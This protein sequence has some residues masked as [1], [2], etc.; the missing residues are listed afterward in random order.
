MEKIIHNSTIN[1]ALKILSIF[2]MLFSG[3]IGI[4]NF[5]ADMKLLLILAVFMLF[6]V[7][8]PGIFLVKRLGAGG[9]H[10]STAAARSFFAGFALNVVLYFI[11]EL[12]G[13]D[14]ILYAAGPLLSA[15]LIAGSIRS[16][17]KPFAKAAR[18]IWNGSSGFYVF[19][20]FVFLYSIM[21]TQYTYISPAHIDY[22]SIKP[23]FG[24]HAGIINALSAGFP[25]KDP[26]IDGIIIE[27]HYF[28]EMLWSIPVRLFGLASEELLLSG[29]PYVITPV[30]S[31]SLYSFF[32]EF[33]VMKERAG[34]Y[35][36][37]LHFSNMFMLRQFAYS[38]FL[39]HI[40][41]NINNAGM[42]ISC[43][44]VLLPML[45]T[46]D[47]DSA[48]DPKRFNTGTMLF[49]AALVMLATGIKGPV[50]I[51]FV[52]GIIG[53][54]LL[55]CIL[56]KVDRRSFALTLLSSISFVLIY[57]YILGAQGSQESNETGGKLLN[58]FE[59]TDVFFLKEDIMA[60]SYPRNVR[61][62]LLFCIFALFLFTA[63]LLPFITGYLREI[64]L[65]LT[66]R[67]EFRFSRISVYACALVGFLGLMLLNFSGH[68]Q[69]YFGFITCMLAPVISFWYFE[70][71]HG[72]KS[73]WSGLVKGVFVLCLCITAATMLWYMYEGAD[74]AVDYYRNCGKEKSARYRNVSTQEYEGLI[75][76]RDNTDRDALIASDRYYSAPLNE[77]DYA[78][79]GHNTHFGYAIYS[80]RRQY[81]EGAGFSLDTGGNELRRSMIET[82]D[83]LYDPD[84]AQ[85]GELARSL[86]IDYV[87][88]S[89]RFNEAGDLSNEDYELCFTNEAMDIYKVKQ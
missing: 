27:Y 57:V 17:E 81:M 45:R 14:V 85:R 89:K 70:D 8:F 67:R 42:G 76:L 82:N 50:A 87:V 16:G 66:G 19:A 44:L 74:T 21:S 34:L 12:I 2:V 32:R 36:L 10:F 48:S 64:F 28:T 68:S 41:S 40:Y 15:A 25:P 53:T 26:W 35:C 31:V 37:S 39:F 51:V 23:D 30:L 38:W 61:W 65:V 55:G 63:F 60:L 59:I 6:Y 71:M 20:A 22:S 73:V 9:E 54:L 69:V 62:V 84:N 43:L 83:K 7:L 46:W 4:I 80:R 77:Y 56:R 88:V 58:A 47:L 72:K 5:K 13:T 29:T 79:R 52:G 75:W 18:T 24:Y 78:F 1:A 86:G 3:C 49:L 33:S 11:A